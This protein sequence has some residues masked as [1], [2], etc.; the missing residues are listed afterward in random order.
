MHQHQHQWFFV[1]GFYCSCHLCS[2]LMVPCSTTLSPAGNVRSCRCLWRLPKN[3]DDFHERKRHEPWRTEPECARVGF[4]PCDY[5][6]EQCFCRALAFGSLFSR[7]GS[8]PQE[9]ES[10][11]LWF[12]HWI[13]F[14]IITSRSKKCFFCSLLLLGLQLTFILLHFPLGSQLPPTSFL[15]TAGLSSA[16]LSWFQTN[17]SCLMVSSGTV[18]LSSLSSSSLF[19]SSLASF[20]M[21][22]LCS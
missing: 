16:F 19:V 6:H 11:W 8:K 7:Q 20:G 4:Y 2:Q 10:H 17:G 5:P 22:V 14:C 13:Y 21:C 18:K 1:N 3:G 12:L 15:F 9:L